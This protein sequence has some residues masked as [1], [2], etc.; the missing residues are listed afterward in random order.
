MSARNFVIKGMAV[1]L[2]DFAKEDSLNELEIK[3]RIISIEASDAGKM[4]PSLL[5]AQKDSGND[6]AAE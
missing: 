2:A 5:Q 6:H 1:S 3:G 4:Q